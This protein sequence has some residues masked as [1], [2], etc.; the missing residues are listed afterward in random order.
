MK[1]I[2]LI[3]LSILTC[4][5]MA[6]GLTSCGKDGQS[7]TPT[8]EIGS[9][10][11]WYIN[12]TKTDYKADGE[13]GEQGEKGDKGDKGDSGEQGEK[14]EKGD[15]GDSGEKGSDGINGS[16]GVDGKDGINGSNGKDGKDGVDGK[17]PEIKIGENGNWFIDGV[18]TNVKAH[19]EKGD[20]GDAGE[21]GSDGKDGVNGSDGKDGVNGSDGKDGKDG[22][23]GSDGKDG[24]GVKTIVIN[25]KGEL[26]I[27][28]DDGTVI[29]A[30]QVVAPEKHIDENNQIICKTFKK[31]DKTIYGKVANDTDTFYFTDE[32]ELKGGASYSVYK[33]FDCSDEIISK[34][35]KL[36]VGDNTFY[37]LEKCGNDSKFYTVT[38]RRR[39]IYTVTF[40]VDDGTLLENATIKVEED[41][42]VPKESIPASTD[43]YDFVW[44]Y[45]FT[46]PVTENIVINATVK[47]IYVISGNTIT[48]LTDYGETLPVL[49]IPSEIDGKKITNIGYRAF[50][51]YTSLTSVTIPDSVTGIGERAFE[52][53]S[54]L[55]SITI[56]NAVTS[57]G[58]FAFY[59]CASLTNITIPDAVTSI[60]IGV[61]RGCNSLT[62]IT[63]PDAVTSIG[64]SA[65]FGCTSLTNITIPDSVTS[66]GNS[67]FYGCSVLTNVTIPNGLTRIE[68]AMFMSCRRLMSITIPAN[69]TSMG[70]EAFEGS[71]LTKVNYLGTIDQW[72]EIRFENYSSN[73]LGCSKKLYINN[74]LVTEANLTTATKISDY[75]FYSCRELTSIT[76]ADSVTSIGS[77]A[78]SFCAGLTNITIPDS[79]TSIGSS[80]FSF[81]AG[82]MN[83]T[84]PDSVNSIEAGVFFSCDR[85]TSITI[86]DS[87]TSIDFQAFCGCPELKRV[88]YKGAKK[89]WDEIELGDG[90]DSLLYASL[91]YYSETEPAL[92]AEGTAYDGNYWRYD[93]DGKMPL[94]WKKEN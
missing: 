90:N 42:I 71:S 87:V 32:I 43:G 14:G 36:N 73:P 12:G 39:E 3:V 49:N 67:A 84:I 82:L 2:I 91:Y 13:K 1:K 4:F 40:T 89:Q 23:N 59:G 72:A 31:T 85:L 17:T 55:A 64:D 37:I 52:E 5:Y 83:I 88:F 35:V 58:N 27:T 75:A 30:G 19:G 8:I 56:P 34:A 11:Y 38:V 74:E 86:P 25:D 48:G 7:N 18:D 78:F 53:C 51:K 21:N 70:A 77:S 94:I 79:V 61:F 66:I 24:N 80:A 65:F 6:I 41:G 57:I 68:N 10:G 29:N 22:M 9:D 60:G 92:N 50:Y 16:N 46:K 63:I 33:D 62:N 69:V 76:I 45:D 44:D 26:I 93:A 20:K 28:L 15:K 81:C 47:A 54:S